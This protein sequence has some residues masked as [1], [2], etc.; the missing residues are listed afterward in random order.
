MFGLALT[1]GAFLA[2]AVSRGT[3]EAIEMV[4]DPSAIL[5]KG[6]F[7]WGLLLAGPIASVGLSY[8]HGFLKRY[9][10]FSEN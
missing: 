8:A 4:Q 3:S 1:V 2:R 7:L 10:W 5:G 9:K 6:E